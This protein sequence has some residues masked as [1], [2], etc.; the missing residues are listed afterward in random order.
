MTVAAAAAVGVAAVTDD[1]TAQERGSIGA[2]TITDAIVHERED[3]GI[4]IPKMAIATG[5]MIVGIVRGEQTVI[6]AEVLG[7]NR[8]PGTAHHGTEA[9]ARC[10]CVTDNRLHNTLGLQHGRG[11]SRW[12]FCGYLQDYE[13]SI[14]E[15]HPRLSMTP[16]AIAWKVA[17]PELCIRRIRATKTVI[18]EWA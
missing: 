17:E 13:E 14:P 11:S 10:I 9:E 1:A 8:K 5:R 3:Q 4:K 6:E 2:I 12:S 16:D 7:V 18:V 15:I